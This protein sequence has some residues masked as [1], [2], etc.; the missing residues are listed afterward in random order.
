MQTIKEKTIY[1]TTDRKEWSDRKQAKKWQ[2]HLNYNNKKQNEAEFEKKYN[3]FKEKSFYELQADYGKFVSAPYSHN[4]WERLITRYLNGDMKEYIVKQSQEYFYNRLK[5]AVLLEKLLKLPI[6]FQILE[7]E[8]EEGKSIG[9]KI[10]YNRKE[11]KII[12]K[13]NNW[14]IKGNIPN[15]LTLKN[16]Q[17]IFEITKCPYKYNPQTVI[18]YKEEKHY[19]NEK[20]QVIYKNGHFNKRVTFDEYFSLIAYKK[21]LGE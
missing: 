2:N 21:I 18:V 19:F 8:N 20:K 7:I 4:D 14:I 6:N 12:Y 11:F 15:N 17:E 1:I 13:K 10:L 9:Y 3:E 5:E 16:I